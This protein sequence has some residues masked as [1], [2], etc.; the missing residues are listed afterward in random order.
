MLKTNHYY[1][2]LFKSND[3]FLVSMIFCFTV[4]FISLNRGSSKSGRDGKRTQEIGQAIRPCFRKIKSSKPWPRSPGNQNQG[5]YHG[6]RTEFFYSQFL[7][8][9]IST[10]TLK[11]YLIILDTRARS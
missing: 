3:I 11:Y 8:Y 1:L 6:D 4:W 9:D 7:N 5:K 2:E 10:Y